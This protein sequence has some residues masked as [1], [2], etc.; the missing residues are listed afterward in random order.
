MSPTVFVGG[1]VAVVCGLATVAVWGGYPALIRW[2][3]RSRRRSPGGAA[4]WSTLPSV[5]VILATREPAAVVAE[6]VRNLLDT[7]YPADQLQVVVAIDGASD[8]GDYGDGGL[9]VPRVR[10]VVGD[11]PG[12]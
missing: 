2:L 8:P 5:S 7:A 10:V 3:G 1:V 6:R 11:P 12:G 9:G 4:A